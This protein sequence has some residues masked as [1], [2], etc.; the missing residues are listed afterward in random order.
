MTNVTVQEALKAAIRHIEANYML[1]SDEESLSD[2]NQC[3][4]VLS[5]IEKCEPVAWKSRFVADDIDTSPEWVLH[6]E[7]PEIREDVE[8]IPLYTSPKPREWVVPSNEVI[9][10]LW[11]KATYE[12]VAHSEPFTRYRFSELLIKQLNTK[13]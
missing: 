11:H 4:A 2:L 9:D 10:T 13:G 3:K 1:T 7:A 12:S 5:D 8:V 6:F